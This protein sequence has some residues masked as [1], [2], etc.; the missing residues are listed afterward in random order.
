MSTA[1]KCFRLSSRKMDCARASESSASPPRSART[2][3]CVYS[4]SEEEKARHA[5]AWKV[6][7]TEGMS[8][9]GCARSPPNLY[10]P[11]TH[12]HTH[13]VYTLIHTDTYTHTCTDTSKHRYRYTHYPY[14]SL[15]FPLLQEDSQP[16]S[17]SLYQFSLRPSLL[18]LS[19]ACVPE[20]QP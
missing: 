17:V 3:V 19:L 9:L 15:R 12:T 14:L 18:P 13:I 16:R 6:H 4:L 20:I 5:Q 7:H 2:S 8:I 11:H 1:V 10:P